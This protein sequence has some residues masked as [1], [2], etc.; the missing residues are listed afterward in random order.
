MKTVH[1]AFRVHKL[2]ETGLV[3]AG[4]LA[5]A[6]DTLLE[7]LNLPEG[8]YKALVITK[9]EEASFFAKKAIATQQENQLS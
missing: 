5:E 9:L 3:R 7:S 1:E 8:R 2:N 4:S 6:F